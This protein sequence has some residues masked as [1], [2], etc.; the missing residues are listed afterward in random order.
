VRQVE[1]SGK[2]F[3][4]IVMLKFKKSDRVVD[5]YLGAGTVEKVIESSLQKGLVVAYIVLFDKTPDVRYNMA[6]N[7]T[8]VFPSSLKSE[9]T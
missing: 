8:M 9:S 4:V 5:D 2:V 7:P 3:K 6:Q 1:R